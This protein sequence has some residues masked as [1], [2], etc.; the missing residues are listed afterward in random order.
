MLSFIV[1]FIFFVCL[2]ALLPLLQKKHCDLALAL[3]KE[4]AQ[5]RQCQHKINS[6]WVTDQRKQNDFIDPWLQ[7]ILINN[8]YLQ[9]IQTIQKPGTP[10][11]KYKEK[12][13][14]FF[15]CL[16]DSDFQ[17]SYI[18]IVLASTSTKPLPQLLMSNRVD[19]LM[20]DSK[21]K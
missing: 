14:V 21:E 2:L 15:F 20:V 9:N 8:Q 12:G 17:I 19:W 16:A 10:T 1:T 11:Y 3:H 6:C 7:G 18:M 5:H 4:L 13:F